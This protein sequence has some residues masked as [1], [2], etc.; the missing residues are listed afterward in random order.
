MLSIFPKI[1]EL[2]FKYDQKS[3]QFIDS[4]N[5]SDSLNEKIFDKVKATSNYKDQKFKAIMN[6][7]QIAKYV[8]KDIFLNEFNDR[9]LMSLPYNLCP[10]YIKRIECQLNQNQLLKISL[11]NFKNNG[12]QFFG[13]EKLYKKNPE[14]IKNNIEKLLGDDK[15]VDPKEISNIFL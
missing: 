12:Q 4:Q 1:S 3:L 14:E 2:F 13:T 10:M 5:K 7:R 6:L 8:M 15:E 11:K 9:N